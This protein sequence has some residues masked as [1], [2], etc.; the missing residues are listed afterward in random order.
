MAATSPSAV[1]SKAS[2]M[3]GATT[4]RLVV[5]DSEIPMKEFMMPQTVPNRPTNG[6][7]APVVARMPTPRE[8]CR[9]IAAS[10]RSSRNA[11]RSLNPSSMV[12]SDS[13]A[14]RAVDR[15][16]CATASLSASQSRTASKTAAALQYFEP[17]TCNLL[18]NPQL[19]GLG[20][21]NRPGHERGEGQ[22]NHHGLHHDI[23]IEEHAPRRKVSRQQGA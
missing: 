14:S 8:T 13:S 21:P 10:T 17:A 23:G 20:E 1:A 12:P 6:A 7:V 11:T 15:M 22:A 5:W 19:N 2:A 9:V 4:A 16:S 18:R 3:P